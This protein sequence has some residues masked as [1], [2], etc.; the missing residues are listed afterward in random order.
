MGFAVCWCALLADKNISRFLV[1]GQMECQADIAT[2]QKAMEMGKWEIVNG[3]VFAVRSKKKTIIHICKVVRSRWR[4]T[5]CYR[6]RVSI[7]INEWLGKVLAGKSRRPKRQNVTLMESK[8]ECI[9][10]GWWVTSCEFLSALASRWR[11]I[12][13]RWTSLMNGAREVEEEEAVPKKISISE[14]E[15]DGKV[16]VSPW[17]SSSTRVPPSSSTGHTQQTCE[18]SQCI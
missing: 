10:D 15:N 9:Y 1:M 8:F 2:H 5:M 16:S 11:V 14:Y 18:H 3:I 6:F 7:I 12:Q 13:K 17:H 4:S